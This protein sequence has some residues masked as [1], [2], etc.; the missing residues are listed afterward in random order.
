MTNTKGRFSNPFTAVL[1]G[2]A[3]LF[4]KKETVRDLTPEDR[5]DGKICLVT[6][7]N[8]GL[9][10]GITVQL[11]RRGAHVIMGCRK[12]YED[13]LQRAKDLSGSE[14]IEI[15]TVDLSD[16]SSIYKFVVELKADG[17]RLD[18]SIHNAGVTPPKARKTVD[19]FNQMFMVNYLSKFVL[20]N[21]LLTEGVIPNSTFAGSESE[22]TSRIILIS[23][24][25]HQGAS[26]I[27]IPNLGRFEPYTSANRAISLY[28]YN[29]IVLNTFG[30]ELSRRLSKGEKPD[31][32]VFV[33]CPGPV[34]TNIIRDAPPGIKIFIRIIFK[35]FFK[36]PMVAALP[37]VFQAVA[38]EL[39]GHTCEYLH[40]N[41][42]KGMDPKCYEEETGRAL[43]EKSA[44]L[45]SKSS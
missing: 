21:A 25:S 7:A 32:S 4:R 6:G 14:S 37:V 29:K 27:D 12:P 9:G 8:S 45:V 10:F 30:V 33:M 22:Q 40:M 2:V 35:L 17:I 19:G 28:S 26:A 20:I 31:V 3:D 1:T 43:W 16:L 34:D 15:R 11:A 13:A 36:D 39:T 5:L 41:R 44:E 23:S 42:P 18:V 38:P 24:D